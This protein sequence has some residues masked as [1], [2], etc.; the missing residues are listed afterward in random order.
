MLFQTAEKKYQRR[1]SLEPSLIYDPQQT[2]S[3]SY[4]QKL[5]YCCSLVEMHLPFIKFMSLE[6]DPRMHHGPSVSI[7]DG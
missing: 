6:T 5:R 3:Q 7:W 1:M 4:A 2:R